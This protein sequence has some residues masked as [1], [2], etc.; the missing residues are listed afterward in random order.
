MRHVAN[1]FALVLIGT[2]TLA[3]AAC[4]SSKSSGP[5]EGGT[6]G[7]SG[8]GGIVLLPSDTGYLDGTNA[9]GVLGPWYAY[10]DGYSDAGVFGAGKCQA[11]NHMDCS[12]FDTPMPGMPFAP[13][14]VTTGKMCA[15]GHAAIVGTLPDGV[16]FDYS[17]VYG[18][19]IAVDLNNMGAG[20][21]GVNPTTKGSY[22]PTTKTP[23]ITGI[24]FDIDMPPTN[25]MR[26]ELPTNAAPG[27]AAGGGTDN[28]AAWWGGG[29]GNTSP[30]KKGHNSFKWADVG[31]PSYLM[32]PPP[33][34]FD[35]TKI[36]SIKWH[37]VTSTSAA[38][39]FSFCV[40]NLTMLTN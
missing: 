22:D 8:G 28:D 40:S 35:K 20:D 11:M 31:G 2:A 16:N 34:A 24:A 37:V 23:P 12:K 38:I 15:T 3:V 33:P 32:N 19:A 10:A 39:D 4:S 25:A 18:A 6:G 26:V 36:T 9:A 1:N 7:T 21:S 13:S 30:I 17:N 5:S 27:G 29:T 14:D